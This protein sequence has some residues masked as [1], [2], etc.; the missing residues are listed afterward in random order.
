MKVGAGSKKR[1]EGV[2]KEREREGGKRET[3]TAFEKT[4]ARDKNSVE[5]KGK[6]RD[7]KDEEE[8]PRRWWPKERLGRR[9]E[10]G[11]DATARSSSSSHEG[12]QRHRLRSIHSDPRLQSAD[13]SSGSEEVPR[14]GSSARASE[15]TIRRRERQI[16]VF[17]LLVNHHSG[18]STFPLSSGGGGEGEDGRS[19]GVRSNGSVGEEGVGVVGGDLSLPGLGSTELPASE[20]LDVGGSLVLV[21][22]IVNSDVSAGV[23]GSLW[24]KKTNE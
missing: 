12:D 6:E 1:Q 2:K 21:E 10:G 16:R 20:L 7:T 4:L 11:E 23:A 18:C 22:R 5:G 9:R 17:L 13:G 8:G 15:R 3:E 19:R 14:L 24:R